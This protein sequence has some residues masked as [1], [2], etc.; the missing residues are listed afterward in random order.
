[1]VTSR[2]FQNDQFGP[3]CDAITRF[4]RMDLVLPMNTGAEAVET[5]IKAVR[6]WGHEVKGVPEGRQHVIA[7]EGN[8]HGRTV[9]IVSFSDD[10]QYRDGFGPF[11]PG[12]SLVPYGDA[13]AL[14]AAI[15]PD[16]VAFLVEPIQG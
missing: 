14:E 7:C 9:T 15:T 3:F 11:T 6:K 10:P 13:A 12:F 16:T 8:F 5:A 4:A 1:T 2:A